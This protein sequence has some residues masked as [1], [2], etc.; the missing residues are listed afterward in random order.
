MR[1]DDSKQ[2]SLLFLI[3]FVY[4]LCIH[5]VNMFNIVMIVSY[6]RDNTENDWFYS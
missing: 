6:K 4:I 5:V 3:I 1:G 2:I